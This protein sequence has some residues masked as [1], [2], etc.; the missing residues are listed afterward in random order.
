MTPSFREILEILNKHQVEYIVVG[1]VAAVIH[2]APMTT[3]DLD[4]LVKINAAN[5][6][7][8]SEALSELEASFRE[9]QGLRPTKEDILA[10][11]RNQD[12]HPAP[13]SSPS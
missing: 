3:F 5:A 12:S 9:H 10:G 7:R 6:E 1:G 2:G 4:T 13:S 8:L 11:E